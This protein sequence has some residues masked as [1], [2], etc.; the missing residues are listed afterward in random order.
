MR[1]VCARS[2]AMSICANSQWLMIS[3]AASFG[4]KPRRPCTLARA[5]SMSMYLRVRFSSDQTWRIASLLK[6]PWKISES[7][8]VEAMVFVSLVT[9]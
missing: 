4:I 5:R 8:M 9:C 3:A 1:S 6:M 2:L 7:M